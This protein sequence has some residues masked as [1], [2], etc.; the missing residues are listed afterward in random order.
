MH[1]T[2]GGGSKKFIF[3]K[4]SQIDLVSWRL[5]LLF[6]ISYQYGLVVVDDYSPTMGAMLMID[7]LSLLLIQLLIVQFHQIQVF[8]NNKN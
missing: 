2:I 5:G 4:N 6:I 7:I 3:H 1:R 8:I